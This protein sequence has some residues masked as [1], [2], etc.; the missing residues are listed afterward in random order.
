[1]FK[2]I[3]KYIFRFL[4]YFLIIVVLALTNAYLVNFLWYK[5]SVIVLMIAFISILA[6]INWK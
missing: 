6:T 2:N 3:I 1:M 5:I 4:I